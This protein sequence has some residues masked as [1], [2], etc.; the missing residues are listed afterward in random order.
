M[1][2]AEQTKND[3]YRE[4]TKLLSDI[5]KALQAFEQS[6]QAGNFRNAYLV[7]H[8]AER[9]LD[10]KWPPEQSKLREDFYWLYVN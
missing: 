1:T 5:P 2:N 6:W 7:A 4:A 10:L 3:Y 9:Q 8:D